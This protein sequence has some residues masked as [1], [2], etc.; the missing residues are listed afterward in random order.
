MKLRNTFL[1]ILIIFAILIVEGVIAGTNEPQPFGI[2]IDQ[3]ALD[4]LTLTAERFSDIS[5]SN[6]IDQAISMKTKLIVSTLVNSN[7]VPVK[8][9]DMVLQARMEI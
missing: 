3:S 6:E 5:N 9:P 4:I 8:L 7:D 2:I 1:I